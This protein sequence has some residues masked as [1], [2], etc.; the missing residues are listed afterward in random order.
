M[1]L[2]A[3]STTELIEKLDT[4]TSSGLSSSEAK[5]R[6]EKHGPNKL[7]EKKK[8]LEKDARLYE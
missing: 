8:Q 6:L 1:I 3:K 2:N 5:S 7:K 4:N